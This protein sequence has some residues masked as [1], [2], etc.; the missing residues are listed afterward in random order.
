VAALNRGTL[1]AFDALARDGVD[2]ELHRD[3]VLCVFEHAAYMESSR[4]DFEALRDFG[5][6]VPAALGGDALRAMEPA[7]SST[8]TAGFFTPEEYHVRPESLATGYAAALARMGVTLHTGVAV[9]GVR[10]G[11]RA[12]GR[13]VGRAVGRTVVLQTSDGDIEGDELLVAAGAWSGE[14][15]AQLGARL[16]VQA[17]KGYSLT[18]PGEGN[19]VSRP[20]YFGESR[21]AVTPFDGALRLA[22]TMELS[23][24]N[25]RLDAR[26]MAAIRRG[27][28]RSFRD[29][30]PAGGTEWVGMRPLTPDGL[31]MLGRVPGQANVWVATG[32]AMLGVTLAPVTGEAMADLMTGAAS[33]ES[34]TAM[35]AFDPGRYRW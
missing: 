23:G 14:V 5:Y 6:A 35:T 1:A 19:R 20:V 29:L 28:A 4:R 32:H 30:L 12:A 3:G 11:G 33:P 27:A 25:E 8:V 22:G 13:T 7:L 16:P 2:F 21:I 24:I 26:R 31:P 17:G 15:V 9:R 18:I 34:M 10:T